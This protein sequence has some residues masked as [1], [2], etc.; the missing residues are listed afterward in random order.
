M[1]LERVADLL[2]QRLDLGQVFLRVELLE[3]AVGLFHVVVVF[4]QYLDGARRARFGAFL[5]HGGGY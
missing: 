1:H 3:G 2:H 5:G 4:L